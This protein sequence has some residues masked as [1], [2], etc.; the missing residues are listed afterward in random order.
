VAEIKRRKPRQQRAADTVEA[1]LI[2]A[3]QVLTRDGIERFGTTAVAER[4]GVSI[5]SLY[6]YFSNREDLLVALARRELARVLDSVARALAEAIPGA[7][8]RAVVHALVAGLSGSPQDSAGVVLL[9]R[10]GNRPQLAA[11]VKDFAGQ[12]GLKIAGLRGLT[13]EAAFVLTHAVLGV[14]SAL[15]IDTGVSDPIK[16]EDELVLLIRSYL[17]ATPS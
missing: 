3:S 15:A 6:Q 14:S 10:F 8:T 5:G 1:V 16:I 2:A 4:A 12:F 7:R 17:E 13:P 11:D 9:L